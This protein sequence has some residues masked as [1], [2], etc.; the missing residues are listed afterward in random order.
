MTPLLLNRCCVPDLQHLTCSQRIGSTLHRR[1]CRRPKR[2]NRRYALPHSFFFTIPLFFS[3]FPF[4]FHLSFLSSFFYLS[5]FHPFSA[6]TAACVSPM[7][8]RTE[9]QHVDVGW[10]YSVRQEPEDV[11]HL[12]HRTEGPLRYVRMQSKEHCSVCEGGEQ[13]R[14]PALSASERSCTV[15]AMSE[16][17]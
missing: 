4:P 12:G 8:P 3:F 14:V 10:C 6:N 7:M 2:H 5:L 1:A 15:G 16:Q 17:C 9:R 13:R 11:V